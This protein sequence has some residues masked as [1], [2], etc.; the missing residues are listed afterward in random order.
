SR[1]MHIVSYC[2]V[3]VTVEEIMQ[4]AGQHP[5]RLLTIMGSGETAPPMARVHRLLV[6][7]VGPRPVNVVL[8][9][10]PY[11]FQENI[12]QISQR[13]VGYF[14]RNLG[15]TP[16][17][18]RWRSTTDDPVQREQALVQIRNSVYIFAGP[19]SPTYALEV[20]RDSPLRNVLAEKLACGGCVTF[21]SAAALTLG[22]VTVPVYEIYKVGAT[23]H[24]VE[25][26]DLLATTGLRAAVIPHYNN[27]EGR[28]HDT[29]FC[30][31][32]E[33]RLRM[34]EAMLEPSTVV[35]GIDEHTACLFDL[36]ADIA[37]VMG[38]G[39]VT[40]R[41]R[42]VSTTF[43]SGCTVPIEDLRAAADERRAPD[44]ATVHSRHAL[45]AD[46]SVSTPSSLQ[47]ETERLER[48]FDAGLQARDVRTAVEAILELEQAIM[49]WSADTE[50]LDG[51]DPARATL[52][53][54]VA[55]LGELAV[56]GTY[57]RRELIA[58]FVD[59][60]I[61]LRDRA[62]EER[63]WVL[64]DDLRDRLVAAGVQVHDTPE[65]TRWRLTD[66]CR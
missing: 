25:G 21:A 34:L 55:R 52:R 32:G 57:D 53:Q 15:V 17:I 59:A 48:T 5:P 19:G 47:A 38:R 42:G 43:A 51:I 39:A 29:R 62:R 7:R 36:D 16:H 1:L 66:R 24:W 18:V 45:V 46:P 30:Y 40:V 49:D 41:R 23:P 31:L 4:I 8:L 33:R 50:E 64:A 56:R 61:E 10:T 26:M 12:D 14:E 63:S 37:T 6:E 3:S 44:T 27:T 54:M 35:L 60:L 11:G 9:E 58:P 28:N 22:V 65:G 20:W 2:H 13:A